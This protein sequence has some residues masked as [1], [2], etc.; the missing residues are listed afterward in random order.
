MT[1]PF[2]VVA[3]Y[4]RPRKTILEEDPSSDKDGVTKS[5][6]AKQRHEACEFI[7]KVAQRL[8]L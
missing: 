7:A 8:N 1:W 2:E 6:V 5:D 4:L 3:W